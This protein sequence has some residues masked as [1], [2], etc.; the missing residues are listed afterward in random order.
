[1]YSQY[2]KRGYLS[3]NSRVFSRYLRFKSSFLAFRKKVM[4]KGRARMTLMVAPHTEKKVIS[5]HVSNFTISLIT[6][7]L[8]LIVILSIVLLNDKESNQI[9]ISGLSNKSKD[10]K[11]RI[12]SIKNSFTASVGYLKKFNH[13]INN[14][15]SIFEGNNY[16]DSLFYFNKVAGDYKNNV[17]KD[18][19]NFKTDL[20][21]ISY[22]NGYIEKN[23]Q[24]LI[25]IN[26]F[27]RHMRMQMMDMPSMWPVSGGGIVVGPYGMR[28]DPFTGEER[29]HT[30]IDILWW[31][32][33]PI[34]CTAN[35]VVLA[36]HR[37]GGYGLCIE[38]KH[39]YGYNTRYAHLQAF[40][41]KK[42]D[43]VKQG[44]IIAAMGSTGKSI[45]PHLHYEVIY[46]NKQIDPAPYLIKKL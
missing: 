7:I 4:Q 27:I 23:T 40:Y 5:I 12:V 33:S 15:F 11:T 20:D 35:G 18:E 3:K 31:P 25:T 10:Q 19:L 30:G 28:S 8:I 17:K 38:I 46:L 29:L 22:L 1:M 41:V 39:K 34:K 37:M 42:G 13:Y 36:A 24:Q 6:S 16:S 21:R 43:T 44:Q 2:K 32:G 45:A 14:L 26:R 9:K